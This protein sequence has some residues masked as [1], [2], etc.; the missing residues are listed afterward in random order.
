MPKVKNEL[1]VRGVG[2]SNYGYLKMI[3]VPFFFVTPLFSVISFFFG[4]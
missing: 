4:F 1:F 3:P 2:H